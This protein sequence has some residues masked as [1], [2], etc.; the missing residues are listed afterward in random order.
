M[1][2]LHIRVGTNLVRKSRLCIRVDRSG[3]TNLFRAAYENY[4]VIVLENFT[5]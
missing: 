3:V 5:C 1:F 4:L 2:M